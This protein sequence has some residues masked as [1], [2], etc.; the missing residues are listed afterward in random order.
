MRE[1]IN[2][3]TSSLIESEVKIIKR[4]KSVPKNEASTRRLPIAHELLTFA[5]D[6]CSELSSQN[7]IQVFPKSI[8]R[9]K[10]NV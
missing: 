3:S 6:N 10:E 5:Q 9:P 8:L 4:G 2:P 7:N 1:F